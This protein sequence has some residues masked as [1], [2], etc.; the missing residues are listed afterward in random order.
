MPSEKIPTL[1]PMTSLQKT[2]PL[3][4]HLLQH[5]YSSN[6]SHS[7]EESKVNYPFFNLNS[8]KD[9]PLMLEACKLEGLETFGF[10]VVCGGRHRTPVMVDNNNVY[11]FESLGTER[12]K[13]GIN[14][15]AQISAGFNQYNPDQ[16]NLVT[17]KKN[18]QVDSVSCGSDSFITLKQA[19]RIKDKL[20]PFIETQAQAELK[21][22]QNNIIDSEEKNDSFFR[23]NSTVR[24]IEDMPPEIAKYS[25][26]N[27]AIE[28]YPRKYE[29]VKD[30]ESLA[31]YAN[32]HKK[33]SSLPTTE[34]IEFSIEKI[35]KNIPSD[36][37]AS[38]EKPKNLSLNK[39]KMIVTNYAIG[40]RREKHE[41]ILN[42]Y[43]KEYDLEKIK[44]ITRISSGIDLILKHVENISNDI[45]PID[46]VEMTAKEKSES[47]LVDVYLQ[48]EIVKD[49]E[50]NKENIAPKGSY[51]LTELASALKAKR[52]DMTQ[53][54]KA[55]L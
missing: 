50:K 52:L 23:L 38:Q 22:T 15:V 16:F 39:R 13:V 47:E 8:P 25:Q 29:I 21:L 5:Y 42:D 14:S 55:Q 54:E 12:S 17:F 2:N 4:A 26:S 30:N 11:I 45:L 32:R 24:Q 44:N 19:F 31:Q 10:I 7:T 18:R 48:E 37:E 36:E 33:I 9:I 40:Y 49:R 28:N 35:E 3:G 43:T 6:I 34:K 27:S 41:R 46:Q 51:S 1:K 53:K 20:E